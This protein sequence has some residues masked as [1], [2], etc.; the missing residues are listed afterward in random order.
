MLPTGEEGAG[1]RSP[2]GGGGWWA[3][4]LPACLRSP[5]RHEKATPPRPSAGGID[6]LLIFVPNNLS[7][8]RL[9]PS[10][11]HCI[12]CHSRPPSQVRLYDQGGRRDIVLLRGL[13][14][15]EM[16]MV[17]VVHHPKVTSPSAFLSGWR[18]DKG[19]SAMSSANGAGSQPSV[20]FSPPSHSAVSGN[21][22]SRRL[23]IPVD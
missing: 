5:S 18:E 20:L 12:M 19:G 11:C 6:T 4:I 3:G 22:G 17:H 1:R 13:F 10:S 16:D 15:Q 14:R 2:G 7:V 9:V 8:S 21:R 23:A